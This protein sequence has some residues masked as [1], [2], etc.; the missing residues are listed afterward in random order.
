MKTLGYICFGV[1][2]SNNDDKI[3]EVAK[4]YDMRVVFWEDRKN[5]KNQPDSLIMAQVI[6]SRFIALKIPLSFRFHAI[7]EYVKKNQS[8]I[9]ALAVSFKEFRELFVSGQIEKA[10]EFILKLRSLLNSTR[11]GLLAYSDASNAGELLSPVAYEYFLSLIMGR[12][13]PMNHSKIK[14]AYEKLFEVSL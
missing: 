2:S 5:N 7:K 13:Q 1:I 6:S 11:V 3:R 12:E 8:R 14:K 4:E 10:E 9:D